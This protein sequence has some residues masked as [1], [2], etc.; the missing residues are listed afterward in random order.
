MD[1][2]FMKANEC[3]TFD[4]PDSSPKRARGFISVKCD[5]EASFVP[6]DTAVE[7][8]DRQGHVRDG[9]QVRHESLLVEGRE[10]PA[11]HS[12]PQVSQFVGMGHAI[13]SRW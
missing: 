12:G 5:F 6:L 8:A 4:K 11:S 7:I 1:R 10:A 3:L 13:E 9:R 2:E